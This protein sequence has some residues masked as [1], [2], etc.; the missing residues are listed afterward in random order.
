MSSTYHMTV[1]CFPCGVV[2][3]A[4]QGLYGFT[5][6]PYAPSLPPNFL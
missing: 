4:T 2:R 6:N 5:L 1:S 3:F